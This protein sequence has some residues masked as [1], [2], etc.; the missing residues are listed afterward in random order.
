MSTRL[1][2]PWKRPNSAFYW[3]RMVVP[4]RYREAI[5]KRE[6]KQSLKTADLGAAKRLCASLQSEWLDR[7]HEI[8]DELK[9]RREQMGIDAVDR[10][11]LMESARYGGMDRVVAYELDCVAEAEEVAM[12]VMDEQDLGLYLKDDREPLNASH[13]AYGEP[14]ERR[15][16]RT[17]RKLLHRTAPQVAGKEA[18]LR[19]QRCEGWPL[20]AQSLVDSLSEAGI[21]FH[22][23]EEHVVVAIRHYLDRLI[24]HDLP[25]LSDLQTAFPSPTSVPA[26]SPQTRLASTPVTKDRPSSCS[27]ASQNDLRQRILGKAA[28]AATIS[29]IFEV[30]ADAQ[31]AESK[32][33]VDEWRV[34]IRRFVELIGD[35]D[36]RAITKDMIMDFRDTMYLLPSRPKKAVAVLPLLDQIEI[37]RNEQLKCLS[38]PTVGKLVSG[39]RVTLAFACDPLRLITDNPGETVHVKN[40]SSEED[41][42]LA[43]DPDDLRA[44]YHSQLLTDALSKLSDTEFWLLFMAP[45]TGL[46]IEDMAKCRPTN[47]KC[48]RSIWYIRVERDRKK[49]RLE[50]KEKGEAHKRGKS[51]AAYRDVPI[52]WILIEAGFLEFVERQRSKK[53]EW[54][55]D[56]LQADK[57][58]NRSKAVSR[59][60]IRRIRSLGITEEEKVFHS[61]RHAMKRACR[62]TSMKEE[63]ADLLAGH[64]PASVGR[65]YGAGAALD[66]LQTAVNEIEYEL[67]WDPVI[68]C[69]KRRLAGAGNRR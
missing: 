37:A 6:I 19:I 45:L 20:L 68:A 14:V 17:R 21:K 56:D 29:E 32:K 18:A 44:I 39:I 64:A 34:A 57:Y 50:Q 43:F 47:V 65:K 67:D 61:F 3:F 41:A 62:Q 31:P 42:R 8:D 40:A 53:A 55:F 24:S 63:I 27:D 66:V 22:C 59:R 13:P 9:A 51:Q 69:A 2:T 49:K 58:G 30:W 4:P 10:Y 7:F 25:G 38:G 16:A 46:R 26:A 54:L 36:V 5:G 28:D 23:D 60:L 48:E 33:L 11:L 12:Q 35:H 52:H 15:I 1:V